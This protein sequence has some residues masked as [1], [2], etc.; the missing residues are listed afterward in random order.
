MR[1][2]NLLFNSLK[3]SPK[4]AKII[5]HQLMLR[6][7]MIQQ[8]TSGIYTWLPLG[9]KVLKNIENIIRSNQDEIG[10]NEMLMSTIQSSELWT[11][12]GRYADYGKEMLRIKDRHDNELLYGPTNEEVITDLFSNYVNSYK[13]L[14]KY[15]YHIQWKFRDEIRPRFGVMRGREFLMKDAY[16]F[17]LDHNTAVQTYKKFFMSY[18]KTFKELGLQPI[19]VKAATGAIGGDLSHEF[20]ILAKTGES[21]LAYDPELVSQNLLDKSYEEI[22]S[23]YSASDEMI[24]KSNSNA[25]IGRGIEVG[26][27]FNFGTKYSEPLECYVLNNEGKKIVPYMGSY[28]IGV[29]RLTAAIIEAFHDDKGIKWPFNISPFKI[30]IISSNDKFSNI[31]ENLYDTLAQEYINISL[32]DRDLS[33]GRKIKDSELIGVPWTIIIGKSYDEKNE[34]EII[35]RSSGEKFFVNNLKIE[36]FKFEQYTP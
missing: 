19:P 33:L 34:F 9:F 2:S 29:S 10:C 25:V 32:D 21:E 35:N 27:I 1:F 7:S 20:Q 12:S 26:H 13:G 31:A 15:L 16:S 3:E 17:D 36:N 4:E 6:S 14:P 24:D 28:G 11:K 30:N 18:L 23:M 5:S 8:H 22:T